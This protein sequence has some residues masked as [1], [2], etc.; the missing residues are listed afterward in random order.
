VLFGLLLACLLV[1]M[2]V[3]I[4]I[5]RSRQTQRAAVAKEA[6]A[7]MGTSAEVVPLIG[8]PITIES[9]LQREIEQ[10]ETGWNEVRLTIP[11]RGPNG[12]AIAHVVGV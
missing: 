5:Q 6:V 8:K 7:H 4:G 11:V 12:K 1:N 2:V 9:G 3:W 10:D